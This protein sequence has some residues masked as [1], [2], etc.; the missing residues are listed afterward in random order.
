MCAV[1]GTSCGLQLRKQ[2]KVNDPHELLLSSVDRGDRDR[3]PA[4]SVCDPG[5]LRCLPR[6]TLSD[7]LTA[8]R[9]GSI[10]ISRKQLACYAVAM[11][12]V[13]LLQFCFG[14]A[15]IAVATGSSASVAGGLYDVLDST[16]GRSCWL[17]CVL[18]IWADDC[19]QDV[20]LESILY[21]LPSKMLCRSAVGV[22]F[23]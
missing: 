3:C 18:H 13:I 11:P 14:C 21:D 22:Q 1:V 19:S 20:R 5:V 6:G 2:L 15:A 16:A 17:R 4:V 7:V 23:P 8:G 9:A 10:W 12:L